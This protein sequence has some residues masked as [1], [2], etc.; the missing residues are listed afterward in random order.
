M[1]RVLAAFL[2]GDHQACSMVRVPT[3]EEEG[4]R[5]DDPLRTWS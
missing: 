1:L 2:R 4:K 5:F 3:P